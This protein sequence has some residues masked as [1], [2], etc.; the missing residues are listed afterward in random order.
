MKKTLVFITITIVAFICRN[1]IIYR[2]ST[3]IVPYYYVGYIYT[4][5]GQPIPNLKIVPVDGLERGDSIGVTDETG[6]FKFKRPEGFISF[7]KVEFEGK[8]IDTLE[9]IRSG[10]HGRVSF[11]FVYGRKDTLFVDLTGEKRSFER[12]SKG[13]EK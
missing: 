13:Y 1:C 7:L 3:A 4:Q 10:P 6:Y 11:C 8:V 12:Y 5:E 9:T 2:N